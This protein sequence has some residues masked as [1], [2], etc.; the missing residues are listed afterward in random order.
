MVFVAHFFSPCFL[1]LVP[2][3]CTESGCGGRYPGLQRWGGRAGEVE[4]AGALGGPQPKFDPADHS[5]TPRPQLPICLT[6]SEDRP[7][8]ALLFHDS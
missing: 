4:G 5:L 2:G 7:V 6:G 1:W 8:L 3:D